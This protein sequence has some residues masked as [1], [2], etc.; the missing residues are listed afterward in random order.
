MLISCTSCNSQYL[1]NSVDLKPDGRMVECAN[2]GNQWYQ[3]ILLTQE[4]KLDNLI[5]KSAPSTSKKNKSENKLNKKTTLNLPSTYVREQN[6]S[7]LN[8]IL[9]ILFIIIIIGGFWITKTFNINTLVLLEF[10]FN[11]FTFNLKLIF[12]DIAKIIYRLIN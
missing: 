5:E 4:N 11:E 12:S 7:I 3:E 6:V 2:C 8:S 9:V 1:V 10:Y